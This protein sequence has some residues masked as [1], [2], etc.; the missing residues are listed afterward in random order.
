MNNYAMIPLI[1]NSFFA[2][3]TGFPIGHTKSAKGEH[4]RSMNN[5]AIDER[6]EYLSLLAEQYPT[7]Q[8]LCTEIINLRAILN[9]P[10]G[11][12]HFISDLHGEYEAFFHIL[13]NCSGVIREKAEAIFGQELG[14]QEMND[15]LTL[16]YYPEEKLKRLH[17]QQKLNEEWYRLRLDQLIRLNRHLSSKYTRSKVRKAMPPAYAYILDELLHAQPDEDNNQLTY[18]RKIIDTLIQIGSGDEFITSLCALTKRLAVD[19]LHI[20]GDIFDRGPRADSIMELLLHYHAVDVEWGNH[21]ILWMGAASG[22]GACIAAVIRNCLAYGNMEIL[23]KG[24]G[25]SLRPLS[26]FAQKFYDPMPLEDAQLH[27]M[28]VILFKLEGQLIDAHPEY[29][30]QGRKLLHL[31]ADGQ[32]EA[33]VDGKNWHIRSLPRPTVSATAPYTLTPEEDHLME[34]FHA[35]FEQSDRLH[36]HIEFLYNHGSLY[37]V[38]NGNL[39]CHGCVPITETGEFATITFAG[40]D[41]SGRALLNHHEAMARRAYFQREPEAVDFMWYMWCGELSPV[42]GR[43]IRTFERMFFEERESWSEKIN[44]Y[45]RYCETREGCVKVLREFGVTTDEG[46][47]VNGH[48]PILANQ[49]ESPVKANGRMII[50]DGGFCRSMQKKTGIAGYTLIANSHG[51]RI[52]AHQPFTSISSAL[53][54]NDDIHSDLRAVLPYSKRMMVSD[55]DNGRNIQKRVDVLE[56]LLTMYRSGWIR[57]KNK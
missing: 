19:R 25:I 52:V 26:L 34:T 43:E 13:N 5:M 51:M 23:E 16:I 3:Q 12:E 46:H 53:D 27:A 10:K 29:R 36:R 11:T 6:F 8:A 9:L 47:I 38:E 39:I 44:P 24:Y 45:Y 1:R 21:D 31:V 54:S 56:E 35:A 49:G 28:A 50:I 42:C 2:K 20:V 57:Q 30:M 7:V 18:H 15:L 48:M 40:Q 4:E 14:K 41:Y 32:R 22:N 33:T 17:E 37:R 55:S